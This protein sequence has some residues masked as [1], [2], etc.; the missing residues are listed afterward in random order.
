M[1]AWKGGMATDLGPVPLG[2]SY[3]LGPTVQFLYLDL[4]TLSSAG[5][6]SGDTRGLKC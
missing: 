5:T 1:H 4:N 3:F 6:P 2:W